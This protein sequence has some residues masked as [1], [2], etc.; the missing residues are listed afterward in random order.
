MQI[1]NRTSW[2]QWL[3]AF[4]VFGISLSFALYTKHAWEDWYITYRSSKNLAMG[5]GLVYTIGERVHS[6]TSPLGT[7]IPALLR[8]LL[9][10]Q[11]DDLVLWCYRILGC[12]L[13]AGTTVMLFRR[14]QSTGMNIFPTVVLIGLFAFDAKIIDFSTNGQETALM[15][16]FL[17]YT[18]YILSMPV[19]Y[20]NT[21]LGLAWGGLM[22]TRPDSFV[23]IIGIGLGYFLF[24]P[25]TPNSQNRKELFKNFTQAGMVALVVYLPWLLWTWA[26]YGTPVPHT[27]IA[28]GLFT[29]KFDLNFLHDVLYFPYHAIFSRCSVV[30]TFMPTY[31]NADGWPIE[32]VIYCQALAIICTFFWVFPR[33]N[34]TGRAISFACFIAH[35]YLTTITPYWAPWYIPNVTF[36]SI[37]VVGL[38]FQQFHSLTTPFG[39]TGHGGSFNYIA[40]PVLYFAGTFL[41]AISLMMTVAMGFEMKVQQSLVENGNRKQ[42]GL[43]LK[44][45]AVHPTDTVFLECLGYIGFYSQLKMLDWPGLSSPEVITARLKVGPCNGDDFSALIRVLYPDWLVLRP[46]EVGYVTHDDPP[47]LVTKYRLAKKFDVTKQIQSY[48]YIPGRD[49]LEKDQTF[50]VFRKK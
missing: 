33:A 36:L 12:G 23:Y 44:E 5:N 18:L 9:V 50:L 32:L 35:F 37:V 49:Y 42:I 13:L 29:K 38:I 7:L 21:K 1:S 31:W 2:I 28:K 27:V 4:V 39:E 48:S 8:F 19:K 10:G 20:P 34:P 17:A 40:R 43:W 41:L 14:A 47:L 11:S 46:I 16:F 3:L 45:N 22:W 30:D 15:M 24:S 6:F 25:K 26:Y